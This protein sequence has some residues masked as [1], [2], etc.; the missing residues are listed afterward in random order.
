[1]GIVSGLIEGVARKPKELV[2]LDEPQVVAVVVF[3]GRRLAKEKVGREV[4]HS[5]LCAAASAKPTTG[6]YNPQQSDNRTRI[7]GS[8]RKWFHATLSKV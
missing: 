6:P 2:R 1:M 4:A 5:P 3:N 8:I 7:H